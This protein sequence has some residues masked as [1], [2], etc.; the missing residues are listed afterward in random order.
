MNQ[1]TISVVYVL[2]SIK[3]FCSGASTIIVLDF[4]KVGTC[5]ADRFHLQLS[6]LCK[7]G[8][9]QFV[10]LQKSRDLHKAVSSCVVLRLRVFVQ[11]LKYELSTY[12]RQIPCCSRSL[13]HKHMQLTSK[14][15]TTY[16]VKRNAHAINGSQ[17]RSS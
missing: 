1:Y 16:L 2:V 3:I 15:E 7:Q 10:P 11:I 4:P 8:I 9:L 13:K 14:G 6:I 17:D 5:S 12:E